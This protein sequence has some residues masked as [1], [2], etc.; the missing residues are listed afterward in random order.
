MTRVL[1]IF[2]GNF[3]DNES[4]F[5]LPL[6]KQLR[7]SGISSELYPKSDKMKKQMNY[8]NKRNIP[9]VIIVGE[10]EIENNLFALKN[11]ITGEQQNVNLE[12]VVKNFS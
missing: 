9:F 6:L 3:G 11:M 7:A 2:F 4:Q 12:Q 1:R 10:Q 8:A 5:C